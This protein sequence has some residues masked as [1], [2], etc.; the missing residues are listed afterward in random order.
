[1]TMFKRNN[2]NELYEKHQP[3]SKTPS[4]TSSNI[5]LLSGYND[6]LSSE[7]PIHGHLDGKGYDSNQT[8]C[9]G[10]N[11]ELNLDDEDSSNV[12]K[13]STLYLVI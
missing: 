10:S 11:I 13:L 1:M 12:P 2:A 6:L 8:S 9:L 7:P 5:I 3:S 4:I